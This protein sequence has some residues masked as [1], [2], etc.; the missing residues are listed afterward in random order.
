MVRKHMAGMRESRRDPRDVRI[1]GKNPGFK[2]MKWIIVMVYLVGGREYH[3]S[4]SKP[5]HHDTEE[6][7]M[8]SGKLL[9][10]FSIGNPR[11]LRWYCKPQ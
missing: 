2:A 9:D 10:D 1:T 5:S 6:S 8:A 11:A 4:P 7:C 3:V